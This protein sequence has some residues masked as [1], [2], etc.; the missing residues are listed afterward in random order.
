M[1]EQIGGR[2]F[3][4]TIVGIIL[5]VL[6]PVIYKKLEVNDSITQIVIGVIAAAVST[7]GVTN[8]MADK[9]SKPDVTDK[10]VNG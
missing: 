1:L 10:A 3:L 4:L 9:Y 7:Y 8:V 6:V 5:A 2:K